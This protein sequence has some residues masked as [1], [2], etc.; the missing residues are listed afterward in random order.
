ML[1]LAAGSSDTHNVGY[2]SA[3]NRH[4]VAQ[5]FEALRHKPEDRGFESRWRYWDFSLIYSFRPH[6]G[7]KNHLASNRT[8]YQGY[9]RG[10]N[11]AGEWG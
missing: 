9:F 8:E 4:A 6:S 7:P 2:H 3:F 11:A 5:L 1:L 10:V